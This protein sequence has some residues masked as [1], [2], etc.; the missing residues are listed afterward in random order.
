VVYG[1][2]PSVWGVQLSGRYV[3]SSGAPYS[4][5][6]NADMNGDGSLVNDLAFIFDPDAAST[7]TAVAASM[8]RV[9]DNPENRAAGCMQAMIGRIADRNA[10]TSPW[11]GRVDAKLSKSIRTWRGQSAEITAEFFNVASLLNRDWG[12]IYDVGTVNLYTVSGFNRATQQFSYAINEAAGVTRKTGTPYE[13]QLG[14][15][16]GF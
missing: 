1:A 7:P 13:I 9:L 14:I 11:A 16:Y 15:R 3:G 4:I 12:G 6:V 8:R 5:V 2:L 10:C